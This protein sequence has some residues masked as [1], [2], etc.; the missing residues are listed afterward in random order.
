MCARERAKAS[1]TVNLSPRRFSC[2]AARR[3]GAAF[4]GAG[5]LDVTRA[6]VAHARARALCGLGRR[7]EA[8]VEFARAVAGGA[9]DGDAKAG[10]R[11]A[12]K[13]AKKK[14]GGKGGGKGS[15]SAEAASAEAA[16]G[17]ALAP[18]APPADPVARGRGLAH[19]HAAL[20]RFR[21][22]FR[23]PRARAIKPRARGRMIC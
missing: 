21:A 3:S 2:G 6:R 11:G 10:G 5:A 16:R 14:G 1:L 7:R 9:R 13:H 4:G 17:G 23:K 20:V 18:L 22:F 8:L 19:Y 15:A 12:K